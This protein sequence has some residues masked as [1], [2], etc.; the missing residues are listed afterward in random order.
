MTRDGGG[1][2]GE[3]GEREG[4]TMQI[5]MRQKKTKERSWPVCSGQCSGWQ[6][7]EQHD[8][9]PAEPRA[10]VW[11]GLL[12]RRMEG[13]CWDDEKLAG[14]QAVRVAKATKAR[15]KECRCG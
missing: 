1:E 2:P 10:G 11:H 5:D 15:P 4:I 13:H 14:E 3:E 8:D 6:C 9:W 12:A 7:L